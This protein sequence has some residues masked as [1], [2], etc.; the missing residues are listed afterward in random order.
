MRTLT[1]VIF[2][3]AATNLIAQ[4]DSVAYSRDFEFK[5]GIYLTITQFKQNHPISASSIV[6]LIP[7][8]E[9][10]FLSEVVENKTVSF[11]D[12]AGVEQKVETATIWGYC[13]N[14]SVYINFNQAFNRINVIGSI[15]HFTA[16]VRVIS[17]PDPIYYNRGI[18]NSYDELHQYILNTQTNMITEFNVDAMEVILKN[19]AELYA[20]FMKLKK[21]KKADSIFIYLRKYNDVHPLYIYGK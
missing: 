13:R 17:Y 15:C 9:L 1:I 16:N 19:D 2:L 11:N 14:R 7:K 8:T 20:E 5:E 12:A 3:F 18:G 21:R 4:T 10:N 6:S